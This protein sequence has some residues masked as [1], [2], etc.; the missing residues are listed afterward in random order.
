MC[1]AFS[2]DDAW[3]V[4]RQTLSQRPDLIGNRAAD[5]LKTL[6]QSNEPFSN[7]E[8]T[9]L[10]VVWCQ[11]SESLDWSQCFARGER[12]CS[13]ARV[14]LVSDGQGLKLYAKWG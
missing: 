10:R 6:Q 12:G 7:E 1:G 2:A 11:G 9:P 4:D 13:L 5:E 3:S 14:E 8:A